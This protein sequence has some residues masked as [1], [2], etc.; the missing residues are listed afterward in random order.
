MATQLT[1][2][3]IKTGFFILASLLFLLLAFRNVMVPFNHDEAVTFFY[4]I[5]SGEFLPYHAHIDANNH[6]LNSG[7]GY[8]CFKLFGSSTFALRLPN[9][10]SFLVFNGMFELL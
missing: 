1:E 8:Y 4:Y 3:R 7:L 10:L 2:K 9:L 6:V 5:Q